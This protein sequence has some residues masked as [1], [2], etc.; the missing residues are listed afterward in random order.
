MLPLILLAFRHLRASELCSLQVDLV[1][2]VRLPRQKRH[3]Y[4]Q[5]LVMSPNPRSTSVRAMSVPRHPL[6]CEY[7]PYLDAG[8]SAESDLRQRRKRGRR[9]GTRAQGHC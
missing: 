8:G 7:A 1:A 5:L 9:R 6:L 4:R 3:R 2:F